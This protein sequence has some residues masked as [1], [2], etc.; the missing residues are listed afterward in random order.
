MRRSRKFYIYMKDVFWI[1]GIGAD[2]WEIGKMLRDMY[3][4]DLYTLEKNN[5]IKII[6]KGYA[7]DIYLNK[8]FDKLY[9][10]FHNEKFIPF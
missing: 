2:M 8:I 1:T 5:E 4:I 6:D 7:S 10:E 9:V 3:D